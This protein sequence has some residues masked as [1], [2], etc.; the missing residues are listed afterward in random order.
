MG[1]AAEAATV[2]QSD[3][4]Q[5]VPAL[6]AEGASAWTLRD[7]LIAAC[8]CDRRAGPMAYWE[9]QELHATL[10]RTRE[11]VARHAGV[12]LGVNVEQ[13]ANQP[14]RT[15][16]E[17]IGALHAVPVADDLPIPPSPSLRPWCDP[18]VASRCRIPYI[19]LAAL[20]HAWGDRDRP[21][22]DVARSFE[23]VAAMSSWDLL[24]A[25]EPSIRDAAPAEEV[26]D[27]AWTLRG[28]KSLVAESAAPSR[29]LHSVAED[30]PTITLTQLW[31]QA[32]EAVAAQHEQT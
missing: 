17:V 32:S 19:P 2:L 15:L 4:V 14:S 7:A 9:W 20:V 27:I 8:G 10:R 21:W 13:W 16:E 29:W 28:W 23:L 3:M 18:K 26:A 1:V 30:D 5:F 22:S 25:I 6:A 12:P 11:V 31:D 24:R